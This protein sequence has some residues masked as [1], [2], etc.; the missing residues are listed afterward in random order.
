M[1]NPEDNSQPTGA[2]S[3]MIAD[4]ADLFIRFGN[5]EDRVS[6]LE[7]VTAPHESRLED[8]EVWQEKVKDDLERY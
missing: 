6:V 8:L 7:D 4:I 2:L 3:K 1:Q 5:V